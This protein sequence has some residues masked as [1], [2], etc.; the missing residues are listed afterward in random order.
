MKSRPKSDVLTIGVWVQ[1]PP[2]AHWSG[3]GLVRL[4]NLFVAG[5]DVDK[6]RYKILVPRWLR[7]EVCEDVKTWGE[8]ASEITQVITPKRSMRLSTRIMLWYLHNNK[9]KKA[10]VRI[11]NI[12]RAFLFLVLPVFLFL[13][14]ILLISKLRPVSN[15]IKKL[16]KLIY[17]RARAFVFSNLPRVGIN[18]EYQAMIDYGNRAGIDV[19]YVGHPSFTLAKK[20]K[21]P[22]VVM[23][24]DFVIGEFPHLFPA[25]DLAKA[26]TLF[27]ELTP[28]AE[29]YITISN[30]V[31]KRHAE[32]LIQIPP[33]KIVTITHAPP[34]IAHDIPYL[35]S[36]VYRTEESRTQAAKVIRDYC[37]SN[38]AN[39]PVKDQTTRELILPYLESLPY[40]EID[41]VLISTQNRPYKNTIGAV[42]AIK[43]LVLNRHRHVKLIMTG[44]PRLDDPGSPLGRFIMEERLHFDAICIP[45]VPAYVHAALYHGALAAVQ[46]TFYEGGTGSWIFFEAMSVGTPALVSRNLA[47]ME[48]N[49]HPDFKARFFDPN[50]FI[51]IAD[52]IEEVLD[53]RQRIYELQLPWYQAQSKRTWNDA[54][55]EY[56][57]VF[58]KAAGQ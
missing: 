23:F 21:S 9:E 2:G 30:H 43:E 34:T 56:Y 41:Y 39:W 10:R 8:V 14:L 45:R 32:Q 19:W 25:G 46:P 20:L 57:Q 50:D 24:A 15:L 1:S 58:R 51:A 16:D 42:R 40:E 17:Q 31:A 33:E 35:P 4:L 37:R 18:Q 47:S 52:Q 28:T 54:A 27:K 44:D 53:N 36:A 55:E 22:V 29:R 11:G 3:E 13:K 49:F 48:M 38:R 7:Q 6:V 5:S 12:N 26:I